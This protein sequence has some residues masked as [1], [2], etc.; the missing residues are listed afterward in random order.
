MLETLPLYLSSRVVQL[1]RS[2]VAVLS[3]VPCKMGTIKLF[4]CTLRISRAVLLMMLACTEYVS[5]ILRLLLLFCIFS[6]VQIISRL[7]LWFARV[8]KQLKMW[9]EKWST[10]CLYF[11]LINIFNANVWVCLDIW[12]VVVLRSSAVSGFQSAIVLGIFT[13]IFNGFVHI[14]FWKLVFKFKLQTSFWKVLL[15]INR[16]RR[17]SM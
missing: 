5:E 12:W 4:L 1:T 10:H 14:L 16:G 7:Y 15:K 11:L 13:T 2:L 9:P 3:P 17:I 8:C 6:D